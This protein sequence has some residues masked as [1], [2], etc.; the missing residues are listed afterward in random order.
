FAGP[1]FADDAECFPFRDRQAYSVDGFHQS[2]LGR[3]D[4]AEVA[5]FQHRSFSRGG[6]GR[7][8]VSNLGDAVRHRFWSLGSS[9]SRIPSPRKVKPRNTVRMAT[10]GNVE[11]HH[12][13]MNSRPSATMD[14]HSA[15]GGTTPSPRNDRPA[16]V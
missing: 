8:S 6:F 1:G 16:N 15:V 13:E 2:V 12:C 11:T 4:D 5:H 14:P 9:Q 7:G 3:E 10:P